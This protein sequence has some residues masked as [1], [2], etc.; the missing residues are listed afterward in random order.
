[1]TSVDGPVVYVDERMEFNAEDFQLLLSYFNLEPLRIIGVHG[2]DHDV[3]L[4]SLLIGL[5]IVFHS[6]WL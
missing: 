3:G 4:Y 1:M 5:Q 2:I 6:I